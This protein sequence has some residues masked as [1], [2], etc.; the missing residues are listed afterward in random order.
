MDSQQPQ[1]P[2]GTELRTSTLDSQLTASMEVPREEPLFSPP[3]PIGEPDVPDPFLKEPVDSEE[4]SV[5]GTEEE[6]ISPSATPA[7]EEVTLAPAEPATPSLSR[8]PNLNKSVPPTPLLPPSDDEDEDEAP[9]FYLP[10]LTLPTM[11]LPIPNVRY[12]V[13]YITR[14]LL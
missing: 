4:E 11:F 1:H 13:S 9:E 14:W 6:G 8:S 5:S 3:A 7:I 2:T 12:P 10:G